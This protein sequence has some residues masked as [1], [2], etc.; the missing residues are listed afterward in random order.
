AYGGT[1]LGRQEIAGE[2][3]ADVEGALWSHA[4]FDAARVVS[5]PAVVRIVV[6]VDPPAGTE[7]GRGGDACG[8]VAVGLGRDGRG[9]VLE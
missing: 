4:Q 6:A 9:Y 8:I 1:R 3:L 7:S 2:M 5:A